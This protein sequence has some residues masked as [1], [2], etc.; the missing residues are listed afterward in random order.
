MLSRESILKMT[1]SK[2]KE[3]I[4]EEDIIYS[5]SLFE[6]RKIEAVKVA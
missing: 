2:V 6:K 1:E 5:C 4:K 3:S